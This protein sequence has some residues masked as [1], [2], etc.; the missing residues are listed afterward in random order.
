MIGDGALDAAAAELLRAR[1]LAEGDADTIDEITD[2]Q[3]TTGR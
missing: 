1:D 2:L 3:K